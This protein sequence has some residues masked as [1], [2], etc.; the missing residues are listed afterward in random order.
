[1]HEL[2]PEGKSAM[3][4][5][6]WELGFWEVVGEMEREG[7]NG[8]CD[9]IFELGYLSWWRM[10]GKKKGGREGEGRGRRG[11]GE[12]GVNRMEGKREGRGWDELVGYG[13]VR[14]G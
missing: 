12:E 4:V 8:K 13:E 1:M 2:L 6:K 5:A 7:E 9:V 10:E 11:G 14:T 3:E